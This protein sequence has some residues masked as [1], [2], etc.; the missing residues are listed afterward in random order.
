MQGLSTASSTICITVLSHCEATVKKLFVLGTQPRQRKLWGDETSLA[1]SV[2]EACQPPDSPWGCCAQAL[3]PT[4]KGGGQQR[5]GAQTS[6]AFPVAV[7]SYISSRSLSSRAKKEYSHT[8]SHPLPSGWLWHGRPAPVRLGVRYG[9]SGAAVQAATAA[10]GGGRTL[11]RGFPSNPRGD[12]NPASP[13]ELW[14]FS[15]HVLDGSSRLWKP[16]S[17]FVRMEI[18]GEWEGV[19]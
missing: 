11:L 5:R 16:R 15:P 19:K 18:F 6:L 17:Y 12:R 9:S 8:K 7:S 10:A 4:G 2:L 14:F 3:T 1:L 13:R